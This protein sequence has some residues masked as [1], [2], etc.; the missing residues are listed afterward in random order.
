[1]KQYFVSFLIFCSL[2]FPQSYSPEDYADS[3]LEMEMYEE[4]REAYQGILEEE[5][6]NLRAHYGM[7]KIYYYQA[8]FPNAEHHL[9]QVV[10]LDTGHADARFLL[11]YSYF[12]QGKDQEAINEWI[13]TIKNDP[14]NIDAYLA[15]SKAYDKTDRPDLAIEMIDR[16]EKKGAKP[17]DIARIRMT[18][19]LRLYNYAEAYTYAKN[20]YS[21]TKNPLLK[22]V[23][24]DIKQKFRPTLNSKG[25]YSQETERDLETRIKTIR[26]IN[27]AG[28]FD[29]T[30]PLKRFIYLNVGCNYFQETQKNLLRRENNFDVS[31]I[32]PSMSILFNAHDTYQCILR[33]SVKTGLN[34]GENLFYFP[35]DTRYE[36]SFFFRYSPENYRFWFSETIDSF[37]ARNFTNSTSYF[38][39]RATSLAGIE[40]LFDSPKN[41]I[42]I[43]GEV[44]SY[45]GS[46]HSFLR[47]AAL[48]TRFAIPGFSNHL[49]FQGHAIY[50]SFTRIDPDFFTYRE[51]EQLISELKVRIPAKKLGEFHIYYTLEYE[52]IKDFIQEASVISSAF[53]TASAPIQLNRFIG[54]SILLEHEFTYKDTLISTTNFKFYID[55]ND[56]I[57]YVG[58]LYFKWIF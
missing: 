21:I 38:V 22:P 17:E 31:Q 8:D 43:E 40:K 41:A 26:I 3:F 49:S 53:D 27:W 33:Q 18:R 4:A 34:K 37:V 58:S 15:L 12:R 10:R 51:R 13:L 46:L 45:R 2:L 11:G 42:G 39:S 9:K 32:L 16:A 20:L 25:I 55:Q 1:M 14:E 5:E 52:R 19:A 6:E 7:G 36:P 57:A 44:G 56:Y 29:A 50:G 23:L 54:N 24:L 28:L 47:Q 30:I 35:Q 48:Y